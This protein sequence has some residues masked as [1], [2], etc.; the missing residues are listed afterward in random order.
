MLRLTIRTDSTLSLFSGSVT[1]I[2]LPQDVC[3]YVL[4]QERR[5]LMRHER[6]I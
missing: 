1:E 5:A 3:M 2:K 6:L 4:E